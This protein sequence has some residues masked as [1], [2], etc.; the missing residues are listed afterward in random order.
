MTLWRRER[1][2]DRE[3]EFF[4]DGRKRGG[5]TYDLSDEVLKG[6]RVIERHSVRCSVVA[7]H[8]VFQH[9]IIVSDKDQNAA[10]AAA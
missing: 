7:C 5:V 4:G 9:F 1:E 10:A 8:T 2:R 6:K 3:R